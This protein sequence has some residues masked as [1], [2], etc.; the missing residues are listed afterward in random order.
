MDQPPGDGVAAFCGSRG[1]C[2]QPEGQ[3]RARGPDGEG[4]GCSVCLGKYRVFPN[5]PSTAKT[6]P[7]SSGSW[8]TV[9]R[10]DHG[11]AAEHPPEQD[12]VASPPRHTLQPANWLRGPA[13]QTGV[14]W[15]PRLQSAYCHH[16]GQGNACVIYH[17]LTVHINS[18]LYRKV[19]GLKVNIST[20]EK[21]LR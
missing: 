21:T 14:S 9:Q 7:F 8:A 12:S 20:K 11:V 5:V 13:A 18:F 16:Q 17:R 1:I 19:Y 10:G 2:S 4:V 15:K 3:R 6:F